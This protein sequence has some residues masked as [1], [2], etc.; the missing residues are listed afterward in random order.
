MKIKQTILQLGITAGIMFSVVT[1]TPLSV[2]AAQCGGVKTSI[3]PCSQTGGSSGSAKNSG[4]WGL[5]LLALNILTG[6]VGIAAVGGVVY[7]AILYSSASDRT[8]QVKQA[9]DTIRNV[10]IGIAAYGGMYLILNFLIPGGI[11]T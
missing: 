1:F 4:V 7:A 10:V 3:I 5:L 11:F 2:G 8:E 9:K 6:G